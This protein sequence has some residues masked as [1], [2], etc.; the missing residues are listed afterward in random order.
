VIDE[1]AAASKEPVTTIVII[2]VIYIYIFFETTVWGSGKLVTQPYQTLTW[3]GHW[4]GDVQIPV[5]F[6]DLNGS[7]VY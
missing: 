4:K 3:I 7:K 5:F 1:S 6:F 2:D